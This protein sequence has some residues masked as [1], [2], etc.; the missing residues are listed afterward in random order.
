MGA[1]CGKTALARSPNVLLERLPRDVFH[2]ATNYLRLDEVVTLV[3]RVDSRLRRWCQTSEARRYKGCE[4]LDASVLYGLSS[5]ASYW[6]ARRQWR[7]VVGRWRRSEEM[8]ESKVFSVRA[9]SNVRMLTAPIGRAPLLREARRC[10]ITRQLGGRMLVTCSERTGQ[11]DGNELEAWRWQGPRGLRRVWRARLD[12]HTGDSTWAWC[13]AGDARVVVLTD[14]A[15]KTWL[16]PADDCC[17]SSTPPDHTLDLLA[18]PGYKGQVWLKMKCA[19]PCGD[20]LVVWNQV[21]DWAS[22]ALVLRW[23]DGSGW[24]IARAYAAVACDGTTVVTREPQGAIEARDM[25]TG[26]LVYST[27]D[28]AVC[29]VSVHADSG[30]LLVQE[31]LGERGEKWLRL[32]ARDGSVLWSTE[33]KRGSYGWYAPPHYL[34]M[35]PMNYP[36]D[37]V[38]WVATGAT[39]RGPGGG[40]TDFGVTYADREACLVEDKQHVWRHTLL[41][42]S[43]GRLVAPADD[44]A[45]RQQSAPNTYVVAFGYGVLVLARDRPYTPADREPRLA[46]ELVVLLLTE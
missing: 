32:R 40:A 22:P 16:V 26:N 30:D 39:Y 12:G 8:V 15:L 11:D 9:V 20:V 21:R 35:R 4:C 24:T 2:H 36:S 13:A 46:Y 19:N 34:F 18:V 41:A 28:A 44:R 14:H 6:R 17:V 27:R 10:E 45:P 37:F 42:R 31:R 25:V 5:V 7:R 23:A 3:A 38:A 29:R 43:E 33:F 1:V